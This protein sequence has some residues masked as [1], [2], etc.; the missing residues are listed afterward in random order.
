V[1]RPPLG[2]CVRGSSAW[3][4]WQL[5]GDALRVRIGQLERDPSVPRNVVRELR[6]MAADL[7]EAAA[8]YRALV[9]RSRSVV[10]EATEVPPGGVD[11]VLNRPLGWDTGLVARELGCS[12][13]WVTSLCAMGR[14]AA[15]K[16]GRAWLIDPV[17]VEDY[18]LRGADAA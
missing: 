16:R 15:I 7:E 3:I 6:A 12:E 18:K 13:R 5:V 11:A 10:A 14:L 4:I 1:T 9:D 17:S 8:Q 2:A